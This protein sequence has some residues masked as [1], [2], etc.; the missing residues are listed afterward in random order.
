MTAMIVSGRISKKSFFSGQE[1]MWDEV[2]EGRAAS[3]TSHTRD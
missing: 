1:V 2:G 3:F